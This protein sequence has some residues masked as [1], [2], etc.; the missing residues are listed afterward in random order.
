MKLH[1]VVSHIAKVAI[2]FTNFDL[3]MSKCG[4]GT[5]VLVINYLNDS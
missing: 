2:V 3:W 4:M 1:D 5:F